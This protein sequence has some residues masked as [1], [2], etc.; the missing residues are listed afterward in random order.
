MKSI[1]MQRSVRRTVRPCLADTPLCTV[2]LYNIILLMARYVQKKEPV[3]AF[4]WYGSV[5][6]NPPILTEL[7]KKKREYP[8]PISC[9]LVSDQSSV[10]LAALA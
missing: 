3:L 5:P 2:I 8:L 1:H 9:M 6:T 7:V 4:Y 10:G